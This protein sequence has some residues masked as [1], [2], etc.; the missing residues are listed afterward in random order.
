MFPEG[1]DMNALLQ[2]AQAM[3]EQLQQAQ[4]ELATVSFTGTAG[5]GLVKATVLGSG[6]LVGLEISPDAVDLEDLESLS[7]LVIA[8]VRD[9]GSQAA[10]HMQAAM[11]QMPDLGSLGM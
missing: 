8:A 7:D 2:Q 10:T 11:P 6:E 3:Q 1:F 5:G 9:A 4:D